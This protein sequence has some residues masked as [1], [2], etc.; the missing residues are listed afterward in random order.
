MNAIDW[1]KCL[2]IAAAHGADLLGRNSPLAVKKKS[3]E[4]AAG[5]K[6]FEEGGKEASETGADDPDEG[7]PNSQRKKKAASATQEDLDTEKEWQ[8]LLE[9]VR[10]GEL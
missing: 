4:R 6:Y 1:E 2:V 9:R 8:A 7:N 5:E 3:G 10:K